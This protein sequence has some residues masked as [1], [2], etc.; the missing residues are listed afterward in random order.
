MAL[1]PLEIPK[2]ALTDVVAAIEIQSPVTPRKSPGCTVSRFKILLCTWLSRATC[3]L[4]MQKPFR[5]KRHPGRHPA[6]GSAQ[7]CTAGCHWITK[8]GRPLTGRYQGASRMP[9]SGYSGR[10]RSIRSHRLRIHQIPGHG[11]SPGDRTAGGFSQ[12][13]FI[14]AGMQTVA[15]ADH[16]EVLHGEPFPCGNILYRKH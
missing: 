14:M 10:C 11:G 1:E 6:G 4:V 16:A 13:V 5:K 9:V 12:K 7:A 2:P 8:H 3:S 15:R